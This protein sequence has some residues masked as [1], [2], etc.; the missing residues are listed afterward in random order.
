MICGYTTQSEFESMAQTLGLSVSFG[1]AD[2]FNF[3]FSSALTDS[4]NSNRPAQWPC[5]LFVADDL[6]V[7]GEVRDLGR[8]EG[9]FRLS[10]GLFVIRAVT[11][12]P[13]K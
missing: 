7:F 13:V 11:T 1:K 4:F 5:A 9:A 3:T 6:L 10:D 12:L 8:I 2:E